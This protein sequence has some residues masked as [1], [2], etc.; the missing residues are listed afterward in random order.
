MIQA[1]ERR[2]IYILISLSMMHKVLYHLNK[3]VLKKKF[4]GKNSSGII[5]IISSTLEPRFLIE[6]SALIFIPSVAGGG[7]RFQPVSPSNNSRITCPYTVQ[8]ARSVRHKESSLP[9][10]PE[11]PRRCLSMPRNRVAFDEAPGRPGNASR[12]RLMLTGDR[13]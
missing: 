1:L 12:N 3:K 10:A 4:I 11:Y 5:V 13:T 2:L 8:Q 6:V 7:F 9:P